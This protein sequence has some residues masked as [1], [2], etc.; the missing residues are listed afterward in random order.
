M[1]AAKVTLFLAGSEASF[2]NFG[3]MFLLPEHL[4]A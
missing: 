4:A 3:V 1:Q 2:A